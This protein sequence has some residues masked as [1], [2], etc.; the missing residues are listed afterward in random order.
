M[1]SRYTN[2]RVPVGVNL[3][4]RE[5]KRTYHFP[6]N[7]KVILYNLTKIIVRQSCRHRI[8]TA[9]GRLHIIAKDWLHIEI[10]A[11]GEWAF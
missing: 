3:E 1:Q 10:E 4:I 6:N 2:K 7:E 8:K 5:R 9:D 11:N